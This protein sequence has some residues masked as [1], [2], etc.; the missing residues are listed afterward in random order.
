MK[1]SIIGIL[2]LAG[3]VSVVSCSDKKEVQ[4]DMTVAKQ[5][6]LIERSVVD[7][8]NMVPASDF[9]ELRGFVFEV[10]GIASEMDMS[11]LFLVD[12]LNSA[13]KMAGDTIL[14]DTISAKIYEDLDYDCVIESDYI[15]FVETS[16]LLSNFTGHYTATDTMTWAYTKANDLQFIFK[17][18]LDNNC[19]LKI[20][21][22]GKEVKLSSPN[23]KTYLGGSDYKREVK[24]D[25]VYYTR[26]LLSNKYE[27]SI[28]EKIT[29]SL[30][31]AKKDVVSATVK[32]KLGN[33]SDGYFDIATGKIGVE[34]TFAT[35][36]GY[37]LSLSGDYEANKAVSSAL[38]LKKS[39]KNVFS[40]NLSANP[41]G[42]PGY[43][44]SGDFEFSDFKDS[45]FSCLDSMNAKKVYISGNLMNEVKLVA[46]ISDIQKYL[47]LSDSVRK[48]VNSEV[49]TKAIVNEL[50][51][52]LNAYVCF[53]GADKK[54]AKLLFE[55]DCDVNYNGSYYEEM[56]SFK[57][58][59]ALADG[60]RT[61]LKEFFD[62]EQ[63]QVAAIALRRML[64]QYRRMIRTGSASRSNKYMLTASA[65]V[66]D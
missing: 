44:L 11:G 47:E 9:E 29:V 45:I 49:K 25:T 21:R 37:K 64:N 22:Q 56:W 32:T 58:V 42:I 27:V 66:I 54:Q 46:S 57:P 4:E 16:I 51:K 6:S 13:M 62:L 40:L 60:S 43:E 1:K 28:P 10:F 17:D 7:F 23:K 36:N 63:Y 5:Q 33:L 53:D 30:S 8:T 39:D 50:N 14:T 52:T 55:P 48:V 59:I 24:D 18:S 26:V 31:R 19:V 35:S 3:C 12:S 15:K 41:E 65:R 34:T 2:A 61:S 38:T 20:A